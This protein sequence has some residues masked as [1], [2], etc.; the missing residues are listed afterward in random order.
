MEI[1]PRAK[2]LYDAATICDTTLPLVGALEGREDILERY[3]AA[4]ITFAGLTIGVDIIG[5]GET[6]HTIAN[7][8]KMIGERDWMVLARHVSD[9]R[10][11]KKQGKLAVNLHFQGAAALEG[12]PHFIEILYEIGVRHMI[13]VYN[14]MNSAGSGSHER[15][16]GGLSKYG[17]RLV[18]EMNR[19]G[20]IVDCTHT[21]YRTTMDIMDVSSAP[22][23]FSHSNARRVCD[24]ERNIVDEQALA[25]VR[26][27]GIVGICGVGKFLSARGTADVADVMAHIQYFSGLIG[28]EN[29]ALGLDTVF[30][31]LDHHYRR[32]SQNPDR[33]PANAYPPPPWHYLQPE[34]LP[35]LADAILAAGFSERELLGILGENFLRVAARV[36][37]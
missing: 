17:I 23:I 1:S 32:I 14:Q 12:N 37:Q 7:V 24:H 33:Y 15:V 11:A 5:L 8:R 10:D 3:R 21:G 18:E 16:D 34:Q 22:V 9:I 20:M 13:L 28:P 31:S 6:L 19:V 26:T 35:A 30:W 29:I 4:G 2:S 36:W 27:G 25:C